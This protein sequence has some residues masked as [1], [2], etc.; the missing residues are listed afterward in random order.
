[1]LTLRLIAS[2]ILIKLQISKLAIG[3]KFRSI[4]GLLD[5][6]VGRESVLRVCG[7]IAASVV[8]DL[9]LWWFIATACVAVFMA[10]AA[11]GISASLGLV[12]E[13]LPA[14]FF[15]G[16]LMAIAFGVVGAP[17][18]IGLVA[19]VLSFPTSALPGGKHSPP[20]GAR[21]RPPVR[22]TDGVRPSRS[23]RHS[24]AEGSRLPAH[25]ITHVPGTSVGVIV[26]QG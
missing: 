16:T 4:A 8:I 2:P 19:L 15:W 5:S 26:S 13:V 9:L 25:T 24:T 18:F 20:V 6:R 12:N 22:Q 3:R 21:I 1:M 23:R 17:M 10:V 7:K 11:D 14:L